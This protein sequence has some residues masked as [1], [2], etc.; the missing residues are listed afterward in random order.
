[1]G[2][3]G[4]ERGGGEEVWGPSSLSFLAENTPRDIQRE[5]TVASPAGS[6]QRGEVLGDLETHLTSL[7]REYA[8]SLEGGRLKKRHT[9]R[10]DAITGM[11]FLTPKKP[12]RGYRLLTVDRGRRRAQ[13]EISGLITTHSKAIKGGEKDGVGSIYLEGVVRM[14]WGGREKRKR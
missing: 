11:M 2:G 9:P 5:P 10:G 3:G 13:R 1:V 12:G 6:G 8:D 4:G 14:K 7:P